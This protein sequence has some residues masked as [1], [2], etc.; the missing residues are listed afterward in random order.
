MFSIF[1]LLYRNIS[2]QYIKDTLFYLF[3]STWTDYVVV[4][5]IRAIFDILQKWNI[6]LQ[7]KLK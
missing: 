4:L 1:V 5:I 3:L 7:D 2:R 6:D